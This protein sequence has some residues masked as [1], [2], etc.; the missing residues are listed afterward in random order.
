M[1]DVRAEELWDSYLR[2]AAAGGSESGFFRTA[3][4]SQAPGTRSF[5]QE[6]AGVRRGK[7][8][9]GG[10]RRELW[11]FLC[12]SVAAAKV[13]LD[14]CNWRPL[15]DLSQQM[16]CRQEWCKYVLGF[17]SFTWLYFGHWHHTHPWNSTWSHLLLCTICASYFKKKILYTNFF[18]LLNNFTFKLMS[19]KRSSPPIIVKFGLHNPINS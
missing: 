7:D 19:T 5:L 13:T 15:I 4:Q 11:V 9:D 16:M 18:R 10:R 3:C 14:L 6:E 12:V 1:F 8:W 17:I 2:S